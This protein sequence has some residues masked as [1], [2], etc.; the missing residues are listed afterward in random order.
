M[1]LSS[2][3][4]PADLK[5][6]PRA[7]LPALCD[8]M[9]KAMLKRTAAHGGHV[10]SDLGFL[11]ATVALHYVFSSPVDKIVFDVS[12]QA[13]PHKMLTGRMEAYLDPAKYDSVSGYSEPSESEHD[14]FIVGHTSTSVSLA[15][16]LAKARDLK[17]EKF[18]VVA[19]I[20]DGSLTGGMAFE[21]LN[22]FAE[23]GGNGIIV[24]NDNQMSIAPN[25]GG[26]L[27]SLARLRETKGADSCNYFRALGL[28][29]MYVDDGNDVNALIDAFGKVKD[30]DHPIVVHVNTEKGHGYR[31]AVEDKETWHWSMPWNIET[32]KPLMEFGENVHDRT[33]EHLLAMMKDD[34]MLVVINA[35]VPSFGGFKPGR[36]ARA[37][38][39][40]VDPGICEEHAC[41]FASALAKGGARPVWFVASTF[42][43]RAYDQLSHDLA[44]NSNPAVI[45]VC[46]AGLSAMNDVTHIGF[47]DIP[48]ASNIPNLVYLCPTC[49]REYFAMLDWALKQRERPVVIRMCG[50]KESGAKV[51]SD[52]SATGSFSVTRRGSK[53][54][55][56]GLGNFHALAMETAELLGKDGIEATVVNPRFAGDVDEVLLKELS[57]DHALFVTLEDGV[58]AGGFGQKVAAAASSLGVRTI[59][60]GAPK[61][62]EDR[63]D[64]EELM[65]RCGLTP[66]QIAAEVVS[67]MKA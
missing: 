61:R 51:E 24:F 9:R 17:G 16:G 53:V 21:G 57:K 41:A 42:L 2:I 36:R 58:V 8:E 11:E 43:Q 4:G 63:F 28:D 40:F 6:I 15:C 65:N 34:P 18:N 10:G 60:K 46:A 48:M 3:K 30:I 13:Y 67:A 22:N 55:I 49:E 27:G 32:G 25:H 44:V 50:A 23:Q 29:Y 33:A 31:F 64:P 66:G 20:G 52:Y 35:A 26:F 19:V 1:N 39:Q 5:K 14:H 62:F 38:K 59:V 47:F 7:E 45:V 37:G 56:F 12:H 54:A